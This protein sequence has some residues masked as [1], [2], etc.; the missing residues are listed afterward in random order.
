MYFCAY[1]VVLHR[2]LYSLIINY[3]LNER[4][5]ESTMNVKDYVIQE[6]ESYPR[7][8]RQIAVLR[9][10]LEH[11]VQ[12]S[13]EEMLDAMAFARG[14]HFGSAP[15]HVSDK[16]LY[17][18]MNYR[19]KA[20]AANS[21]ISEEISAKLLELERKKGRI[22]YYVGMLDSRKAN[23]IRLCFFEGRTIEDAAEELN[24]S[25]KTAQIAKKKAIEE[26]TDL[27]A[28]TSNIN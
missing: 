11:P 9:Y 2:Q 14:E 21:E 23:V 18:A 7:T 13:T 8:L 3:F 26:L 28:L 22:E 19:Q 20:A 27:F 25:A 12:V 10:E 6:L 4:N 24:I 5:L 15:G 17:I 16:T 1:V